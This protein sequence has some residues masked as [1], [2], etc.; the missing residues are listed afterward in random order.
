M[1]PESKIFANQMNCDC[2][3]IADGS[4]VRI[5]SCTLFLALSKGLLASFNMTD[6]FNSLIEK[7]TLSYTP[8]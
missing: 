2:T 4:N 7:E 3:I 1:K 5:E 8:Y 6:Y